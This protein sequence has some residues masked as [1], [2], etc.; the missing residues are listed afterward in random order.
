MAL[1]PRK[2]QL[3]QLALAGT[4][5]AAAGAFLGPL[6][7]ISQATHLVPPGN[8][9]AKNHP[10]VTL[11]TIMPGGLRG[12]IVN[13]LWIRCQELHQDGRHYD[14][15]QLAELICNMQPRSPGVWRYQA[16]QMAWNI[17]VT[18]DTPD[19]R[20]RWVYNGAKL[21]RDR[22]IQ[23]NP[24]SLNLY[25]ELAWIFLEKMGG[26]MDEMHMAYKQRWA[27]LMQDLLG[28]PPYG[29]T[30][31]AIRAFG[32]IAAAPIDRRPDR[33]VGERGGWIQA[34]P[35]EALLK[36]DTAARAEREDPTDQGSAADYV[37][38]LAAQGVEIN[39]GLLD[40]H[41]RYS[42]DDRAASV[43]NPYVRYEPKTDREKAVR[44]L[45]ND[46]KYA[47]ARGKLLAFV[48]AQILW[49]RYKMDPVWMF[50]L[51][52]RYGMPFDWRQPTAHALYW[53][54]WGK[55]VTGHVQDAEI[56]SMNVDRNVM[57]SLKDLTWQGRMTYV[58]NPARPDYPFV[59]TLADWRY[60]EPTH[61][62]HDQMALAWVL[63]KARTREP[64]PYEKN[65]YRAG[66]MNYLASAISMLFFLGREDDIVQTTPEGERVTHGARYYLQWVRDH[67]KQKDN[68]WALPLEEF[69]FQRLT[70]D[71]RIIPNEASAQLAASLDSAMVGLAL[72]DDARYR[73]Y[74]NY[75]MRVYR[76]AQRD[77][78]PRLM[79]RIGTIKQVM[80]GRLALL[81]VNPRAAGFNLSMDARIRLY[82]R[83]AELWPSRSADEPGPVLIAYDGIAQ[84]LKRQCEVAGEPF[85]QAFGKPA[86]LDAYRAK[87]ARILTPRQSKE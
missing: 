26:F 34:D 31:A 63:A 81:V 41:N 47:E 60:I 82:G 7:V 21:L 52:I 72:G 4:L 71:G 6:D 19:E 73:R 55:N 35:L 64:E 66:H 39:Q 13:Y 80:A 84:P 38:L 49:N 27:K 74:I 22:G 23:Q 69:V 65:V 46:A 57:N 2:K 48:R 43:R 87:H 83:V 25:R 62:Q 77:L 24:T 16:W 40:A 12:P 78:P 18:C 30:A 17:S 54:T 79:A 28:S 76:A 58:E 45:M 10:A 85:D 11:L 75:A 44:K 86:F 37:R 36:A 1:T 53:V 20:W 8:L 70:S 9:P 68:E 56:D 3:L 59:R 67:Y 29:S 15:M 32:P 51:M 33:R 61:R 50:G 5:F 42:R 14:A